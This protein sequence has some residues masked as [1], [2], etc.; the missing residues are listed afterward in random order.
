MKTQELRINIKANNFHFKPL[1]SGKS[2]N[3]HDKTP[4]Q[5]IEHQVREMLYRL[6]LLDTT[7][8]KIDIELTEETK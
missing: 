1:E 3:P 8:T 4:E 7:Q 2:P 5:V 6:G